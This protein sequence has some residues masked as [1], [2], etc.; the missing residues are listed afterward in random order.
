MLSKQNRLSKSQFDEV[1]KKGRVLHSPIFVMKVL[2]N[3]EDSRFSAVIPNKIEKTATGRNYSRRKI[4]N[5]LRNIKPSVKKKC[6]IILITKKSIRPIDT[7]EITDDIRKL[8][9][10]GG[11]L[12]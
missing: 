10:K 9:V 1:F 8:F 12:E 7:N 3:T 4:Y 2:F 6:N 11:I 5:I